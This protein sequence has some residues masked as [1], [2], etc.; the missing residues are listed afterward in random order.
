M[1]RLTDD[2][3][4]TLLRYQLL[5]HGQAYVLR[6]QGKT[7]ILDTTEVKIT[8]NPAGVIIVDEIAQLQ[9]FQNNPPQG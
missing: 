6:K 8:G 2:E 1:V 3:K 5:L 4:L 9:Q 7:T